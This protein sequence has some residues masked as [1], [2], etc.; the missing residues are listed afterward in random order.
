MAVSKK[1]IK[2]LRSSNK[3]LSGIL[4]LL[5]FGSFTEENEMDEIS[6]MYGMPP[7]YFKAKNKARNRIVKKKLEPE[8]FIP[9]IVIKK[10]R[11]V[12]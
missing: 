11:N 1:H 6:P 2:R 3:F 5:G 9:H 12:C 7:S 8:E 10:R 4:F